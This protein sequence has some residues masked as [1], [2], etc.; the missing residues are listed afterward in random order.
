MAPNAMPLKEKSLDGD[1]EESNEMS[2]NE[3]AP[4]WSLS[5]SEGGL[6]RSFLTPRKVREPGKV[7]AVGSD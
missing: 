4:S 1:S 6:H 3:G 2:K 5:R 7:K